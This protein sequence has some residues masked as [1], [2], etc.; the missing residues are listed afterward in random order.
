[1]KMKLYSLVRGDVFRVI[2]DNLN[3]SM[4]FEGIDGLYARCRSP[5]CPTGQLRD[6]DPNREVFK[7]GDYETLHAGA[8]SK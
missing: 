6:V 1:M 4:Y 7:I 3:T 2:G 5:A 8:G